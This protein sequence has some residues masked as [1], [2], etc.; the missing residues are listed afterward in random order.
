[1]RKFTDEQ[2]AIRDM[3]RDFVRREVIPFAAEWDRTLDGYSLQDELDRL[4]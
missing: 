4:Q 3:T 2:I 1:M